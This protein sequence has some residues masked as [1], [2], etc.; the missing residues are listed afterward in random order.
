MNDQKEWEEQTKALMVSEGWELDLDSETKLGFC[1][2]MCDGSKYNRDYFKD[3]R[4]F[5]QYDP[6]QMINLVSTKEK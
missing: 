3:T 4:S 2:K 6:E 1:F 5:V